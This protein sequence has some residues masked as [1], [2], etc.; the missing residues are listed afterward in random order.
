MTARNWTAILIVALVA[1]AAAWFWTGRPEPDDPRLV[2]HPGYAIYRSVCLECHGMYGQ[3]EKATRVAKR[4]VNLTA[5]GFR[6]TTTVEDV[7]RIV[8][9][10]KGRME[11]LEDRLTL[12]QVERV[13][14]LVFELYP[15][16]P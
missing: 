5:P 1:L 8:I 12:E 10:G 9:A 13:A 11:G 3:G 16:A 2:D 14:P 15:E 6:D 7:R 4:P